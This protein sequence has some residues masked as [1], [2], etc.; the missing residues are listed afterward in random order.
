METDTAGNIIY[1]P[2]NCDCNL[3]GSCAKCRLSFIGYISDKEADKMR[4]KLQ[5]WRKRFDKD[6]KQ[7]NKILFNPHNN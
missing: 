6:I 3:T 7:R 2:I 4:K 5:D 1:K